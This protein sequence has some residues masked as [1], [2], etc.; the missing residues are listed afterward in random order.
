MHCFRHLAAHSFVVLFVVCMVFLAPAWAAPGKEKAQMPTVRWDEEH[1][2]CTFLITPDGKYHYGLWSGDVGVTLAVDAQEL[3][4][5]H[6]RN[7][8]IFGVLLTVRYRGRG[9]LGVSDQDI[10]LE[11]VKHFPLIQ[12]SLDPDG[13]SARSQ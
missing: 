4:K 8:P 7:Q 3:A 6:R 1:P 10:S 2:G 12:N 13:V 5:V 11:F 9:S